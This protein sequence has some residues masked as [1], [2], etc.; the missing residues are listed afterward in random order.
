MSIIYCDL[1]EKQ[2]GKTNLI[3]GWFINSLQDS[4]NSRHV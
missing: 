3:P 4:Y 2:R 1:N